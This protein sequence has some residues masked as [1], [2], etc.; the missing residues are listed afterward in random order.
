M[1]FD[2][3]RVWGHVTNMLALPKAGP[4]ASAG[5]FRKPVASAGMPTR[6]QVAALAFGWALGLGACATGG[7]QS[8]TL[9]ASMAGE[10]DA[11]GPGMQA[12]ASQRVA[13]NPAAAR[14]QLPDDIKACYDRLWRGGV[15]FELVDRAQ[16][17]GVYMPIRAT[18]PFGGVWILPNDRDRTHAVLDCR[19]ALRLLAWSDSLRR[20]GVSTV[21]YYSVYRPGARVNGDGR[22]SGHA[23]ALAID[24]A[25]LQMS[26][27]AILDVLTD[28]E[29]RD[30]GGA[31]CPLRNDESW[32]GRVL[33]GI[34]CQA[35][36]AGLF[37][38]VLT[39]HHDLDHQN[40][41]HLE[42]KPHTD[43]TYIQ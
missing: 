43:W 39:P 1:F 28:W 42:L 29:E 4:F 24:V 7:G 9:Q 15:T 27:G 20:A 22:K 14:L 6:F 23:F 37:N 10:V 21:E 19:L 33:R 8:D 31:P 26:N 40:H 16:A 5:R 34:V 11:S 13:P 2:W 41:V 3:T 38:V 36:A 32:G 12:V 25:R 18:S 35:V 17:K 30:I